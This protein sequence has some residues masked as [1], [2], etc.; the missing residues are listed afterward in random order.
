[1]IGHLQQATH[2]GL[3]SLVQKHIGGRRVAILPL[4]PFQETERH[5]RV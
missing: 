5:Q 3:L 1:M 2:I 4:A